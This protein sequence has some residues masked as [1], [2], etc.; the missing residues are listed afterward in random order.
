MFPDCQAVFF[1]LSGV[2]YEGDDVIPGAVEAV[3]AAIDQR[4][5]VR[6]VTN[7]ATKSSGDILAKLQRLG[8]P[9]EED[10]LFTAPMAARA[11]AREKNLRPYALV[12]PA[13]QP[14]FDD[15]TGDAPNCVIVGDAREGLHY[16]SLNRAFQLLMD[17]AT[18]IGIGRNQYF[19]SG[20]E[21]MLDAGAFIQALE[22]AAGV[23]AIIMGKPGA[24][25]FAQVVAST[26]HEAQ[27]CLMIGDD[28]Q[29]DVLGALNAGLRACQVRTGKFRP[30]DAAQLPDEVLIVDS[31]EHFVSAN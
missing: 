12:H 10:Q 14:M 26:G 28:A 31:V 21:L 18:L 8:F 15:L 4:L 30:D 19:S 23:E 20:G 11:L 6:F 24:A 9:V 5:T 3:R 16:A 13:I 29:G 22:Y 1:D 2:L 27:D 25:F 17:G 7:T